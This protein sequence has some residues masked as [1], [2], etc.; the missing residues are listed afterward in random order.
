MKYRRVVTGLDQDRSVAVSD[1]ELQPFTVPGG[2]QV[3]RLWSA[4]TV[5]SYPTTSY[6][7]PGAEGFFPPVGGVRFLIG[8]IPPADPN[9]ADDPDAGMHV[10]DSTD[11]VVVLAGEPVL[12]LDDGSRVPLAVGTVVVQNGTR[13][14]WANASTETEAVIATVVLG[15]RRVE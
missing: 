11:F 2:G 7:D 14:R 10:S 1:E 13:H 12:G 8:V 5:A 4:D 6:D 9:V 15:A 3:L